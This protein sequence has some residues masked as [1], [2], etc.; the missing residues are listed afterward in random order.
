MKKLSLFLLAM[1]VSAGMMAQSV[2]QKV[3]TTP[4]DW[5]GTYLIVCEGQSVV[6]NGAADEANIDAKGGPAILTNIAIA[7]GQITGSETL[8][9]A[10]FC[11]VD[12]EDTDWP[13]AIRSASGLYIGHKDSV[14]ADNGLS[15]ETEIKGKC[16]HTLAID[17]EGNFIATPKHSKGEAYNLQYNKK[18]DQKRFRY[19]VPNDKQAI[20]IYKLSETPSALPLTPKEGDSSK[21][22]ENGQI[23]IVRD[24]QKWNLNGQNL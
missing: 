11:I 10:V 6:F 8:D 1:A 4:A 7:D 22:I 9:A 13:W 21:R 17:E 12:S 2:Y 5:A 18:S 23:V 20:Q 15:T 24:H 19:F 14:V 3:T 16:K